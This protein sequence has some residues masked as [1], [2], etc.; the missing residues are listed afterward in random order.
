VDFDPTLLADSCDV[1]KYMPDWRSAC[2]CVS[3]AK[4][5]YAD[6]IPWKI[7]EK[8]SHILVAE[9]NY[10]D[11]KF[12]KDYD[13]DNQGRISSGFFSYIELGLNADTI[14][15]FAVNPWTG[16]VWSLWECRKIG[17]LTSLAIQK[18]IRLRFTSEELPQYERLSQIKPS[19]W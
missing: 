2:L 7:D 19:C 9:A 10:G 8:T 11:M 4:S 13:Y 16:D 6:E 14:G 15:V 12:W 17:T 18:K 1:G 3:T 5:A